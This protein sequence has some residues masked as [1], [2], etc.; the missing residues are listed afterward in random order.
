MPSEYDPADSLVDIIENT[1]RIESY[2]TGMDHDTF[3]PTVCTQMAYMLTK[4]GG[5]GLSRLSA[6]LRIATCGQTARRC[7]HHRA[8]EAVMTI[9]L[10]SL[11]E[12]LRQLQAEMR[13]VRHEV[14]ALRDE[15]SMLRAEPH[16]TV[17][18]IA[19]LLRTGETRVVDR[20]AAFEAHVDT[21]IDNLDAQKP[22]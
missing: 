4:F 5:R 3:A 7:W 8:K 1:G 2:L 6:R 11:S 21:R 16:N 14:S 12:T 22:Q 10:E 20:I 17:R 15:V 18:A 9:P 19:G 13:T